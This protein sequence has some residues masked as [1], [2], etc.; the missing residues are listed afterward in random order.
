MTVEQWRAVWKLYQSGSSLPTDRLL[1][2]LRSATDDPQV[3]EA[4]LA[5]FDPEQAS[6]S[7]DRAGQRIGRYVVIGRLGRGGMGEVYAARDPDLDRSVAVKLLLES[8]AGGS[9]HEAKAASALSHPNIVTI[10]E[11]IPAE[12]GI[13]IV[14]ELVDGMALRHL[15]GSRLPVDRL[16]HV[17]EQIARALAAAHAQGI[18]HCDIK[19]ENVMVRPDGLVKVLDFGLSRDIV[20]TSSSSARPAGTLRYM[21]PEQSRGEPPAPESDVFSLGIVLYELATGTHPFA[22]G[23]IFESLEALNHGQPAAPSTLNPFV[24][25]ELDT[26]ILAMLA[27]D[28]RQRPAAAEVARALESRLFSSGDSSANLAPRVLPV[29]H[30]ERKRNKRTG[31]PLSWWVA[32]AAVV[33]AA[34]AV[35]IAWRAIRKPSQPLTRLSIELP[36]FSLLSQEVMPGA[37][38]ALSP[39]GRRIVYTGR[40]SDGTVTLY[41]RTLDQEQVTPLP[42]TEGAYGPFF[43]P[44]GKSIGFFAGGKLRRISVQRGAPDTLCDV[45]VGAGGSWGDDG[46]IIASRG[47]GEGLWRIPA[48]GGTPHPLLQ[49][50]GEKTWPQVLPGAGVVLFTSPRRNQD[51]DEAAIEALSLRT[52]ETKIL[53]RGGYFGR[54]TS[55]GHLLYVHQGNLYAAPM[56]VKRLELTGPAV[57]VVE[58]VLSN[59]WNG[60][61]HFDVARNGTL[62]FVHAKGTRQTLRWLNSTGQT[63][64]L[65]PS[66]EFYGPVRLSPDGKQLAI[67]S[68]EH[69]DINIGI[70]DWT[71]DTMTRLTFTGV[72]A[73]P[74]WSPDGKHV[75]F[76]STRQGKFGLYWMRAD[77]VGEPIR[78]TSSSNQQAASS[79]SPDGKR[80]AFIEVN[81]QTNVDLWTLPLLAPDSDNPRAGQPEPLLVTPLNETAPVISPDGRWLA[82]QSN[83]SGRYE[84]YVRSFPEAGGKW[85]V[86]AG[87]GDRPVWSRT[88]HELFYRTGE[89]IARAAYQIEGDSFVTGKPSLWSGQNGLEWFDLGSDAEH[90]AVIDTKA[91]EQKLQATLLL[92]FFDELQR[93]APPGRK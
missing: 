24:P 84:I 67:G 88:T 46:N 49:S 75:V 7:S 22:S 78:L 41:T 27:K 28:A 58:Q 80:L 30:T 53:L 13:A 21:S 48:D 3:R 52:G 42:G 91:D 31:A 56:D 25:V 17:G 16:L 19:P 39:D 43:S 47:F 34:I 57:L 86:S 77:G 45:S 69:G 70:Y 6:P 2:F 55:S 60:F 87:G 14:M 15:C 37:S 74:V 40:A 73:Y 10:H 12:S 36:Q 81:P 72:N 35:L 62:V 76:S 89:G 64:P 44:D 85:Q 66:A 92:N 90:F 18:V 29:G 83:E 1:S 20:S 9:I 71:R 38:V 8:V 65:G 82:Y 4:V 23:S 33:I 32:A 59:S 61:A 11:V 63:H 68:V 93:R 26:L 51:Y 50:S 54:Y 79:F 5:M